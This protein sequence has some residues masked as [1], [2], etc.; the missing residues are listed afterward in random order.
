MQRSAKASSLKISRFFKS[1]DKAVQ[2]QNR[3]AFSGLAHVRIMVFYRFALRE[4][5]DIRKKKPNGQINE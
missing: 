2:V 5:K 4:R 1:V 3:A